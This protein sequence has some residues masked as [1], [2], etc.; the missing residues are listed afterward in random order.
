MGLYKN[1]QNVPLALNKADYGQLKNYINGPL[2]GKFKLSTDADA[3]PVLD[4]TDLKILLH[5]LW[6]DDDK[7]EKGLGQIEDDIITRQHAEARFSERN[8]RICSNSSPYRG[9]D[10]ALCCTPRLTSHKRT[11]VRYGR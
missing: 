10:L 8:S 11:A 6:V 9:L 7:V 5:Q 3:Q 2:V 1:R 4:A